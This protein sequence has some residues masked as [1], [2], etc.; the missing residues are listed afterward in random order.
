MCKNGEKC[1][2][3]INAPTTKGG[4]TFFIDDDLIRYDERR[5]KEIM[6]KRRGFV[7]YSHNSP[8]F[9]KFQ[10][11]KGKKVCII[12]SEITKEEARMIFLYRPF[13]K[14]AESRFGGNIYTDDVCLLINKKATRC[15]MC[16]AP[17]RNEYLTNGI[18]PDCDG[19][20]EWGGK[21]PRKR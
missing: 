10:E 12:I 7:A 21:N 13:S 3:D 9:I 6:M 17:T 1:R 2:K 5:A 4:N 8:R 16:S 20:S 15:I 14:Y 18:C 19:R 11:I